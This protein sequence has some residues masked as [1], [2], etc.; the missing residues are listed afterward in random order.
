[1]FASPT[2]NMNFHPSDISW[3]YLNLGSVQRTQ[4]YIHM[5]KPALMNNTAT[6][7]SDAIN[8]C[9]PISCNDRERNGTPHPTRSRRY[10]R[11]GI[12]NPPMSCISVSCGTKGICQP[13]KN[14]V[15]ARQERI[16]MTTY[17]VKKIKA[18]L[19]EPY[20]V[21]KP[22]TNSASDSAESKGARF[23][24]ANIQTKKIMKEIGDV[25]MPQ[26]QRFDW[27]ITI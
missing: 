27:P 23:V 12:C 16:N 7:M 11:T 5:K 20:S 13:P 17:S 1:M 21:W 15:D 4:T 19:A 3:S 14:T 24:S 25:I 18:N 6:P 9:T 22:A 2:G 26:F 8:E 10:G